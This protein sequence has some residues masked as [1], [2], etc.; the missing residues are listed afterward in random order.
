MFE[1]IAVLPGRGCAAG[2]VSGTFCGVANELLM[3]AWVR[4]FEGVED[5]GAEEGVD[6]DAPA[7]LAVRAVDVD[8]HAHFCGCVRELVIWVSLVSCRG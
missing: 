3:F 8:D 6:D 4:D 5:G 2:T 1:G 7:R